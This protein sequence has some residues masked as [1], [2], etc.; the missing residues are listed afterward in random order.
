MRASGLCVLRVATRLGAAALVAAVFWLP[1]PGAAQ[2]VTDALSDFSVD[3]D[4]PVRIESDELEVRDRERMAVFAGNV[5]VRQGDTTL[6][7]PRLEV[8]YT[9]A[10][11]PAT[12]E[13]PGA[14]Q[15]ISRLAAR[16]GVVVETRDQKATGDWADFDMDSQEIVLGGDVVLTQGQNVLRGGRLVVNLATGTSRLLSAGQAESGRVQGLFIPGAMRQKQD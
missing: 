1:P 14:G 9:A 15:S 6:R 13:Q 12:A 11:S 3:S 5:V 16:G 7:T 8:H 10:T 2:S 4:A